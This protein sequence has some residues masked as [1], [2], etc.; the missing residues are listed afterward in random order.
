MLRPTYSA[1]LTAT[2]E[3][4]M[5]RSA[6]WQPPDLVLHGGKATETVRSDAPVSQA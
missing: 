1:E 2:V 4:L 3:T 6:S 5:D